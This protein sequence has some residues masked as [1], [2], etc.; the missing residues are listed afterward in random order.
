[1]FFLYT[2]SMPAAIVGLKPIL[3]LKEGVGKLG[4]EEFDLCW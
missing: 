4:F 1:M 2:V 3:A